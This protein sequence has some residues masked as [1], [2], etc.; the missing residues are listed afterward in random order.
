MLTVGL[1]IAGVTFA[2]DG[3]GDDGE[4]LD[5]TRQVAANPAAKGGWTIDQQGKVY[6]SEDGNK[7]RI[8]HSVYGTFVINLSDSVVTKVEGTKSVV[9]DNTELLQR[10]SG[11]TLVVKMSEYKFKVQFSEKISGMKSISGI[12]GMQ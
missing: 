10:D 8:N 9:L 6:R 2:T 12:K 5:V 4:W 1:L 3:S 7:I 11:Q